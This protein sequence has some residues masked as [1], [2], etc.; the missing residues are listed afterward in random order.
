MIYKISIKRPGLL[1]ASLS[2]F[3]LVQTGEVFFLVTWEFQPLL[4]ATIYTVRDL[5]KRGYLEVDDSPRE[6]EAKDEAHTRALLAPW[7]KFLILHCLSFVQSPFI[8]IV[9]TIRLK[10]WPVS[11]KM[12]KF[13]LGLYL[14]Q[15]ALIW[16]MSLW[17]TIHITLKQRNA[18]ANDK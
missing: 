6:T 3:A 8:S 5:S 14:V 16:Y 9:W 15:K 7:C 18:T 17:A 2:P 4:T 1:L 12:S 11:P 13:G 10:I